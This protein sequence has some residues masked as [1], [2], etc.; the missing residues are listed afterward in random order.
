M[1]NGKVKWFNSTK[2]FGFIMPENGGPDVFVHVSALEKSGLK[3]LNENDQ[4]TYDIVTERGKSAA[5]NI[6]KV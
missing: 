4:V 5:A 3:S 6:K 1:E 2:G